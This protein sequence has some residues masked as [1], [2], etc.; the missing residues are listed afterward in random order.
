MK[1]EH[2]ILIVDDEFSVLK[3]L[4]KTLLRKGYSVDTA[5]NGLEAS[6]KLRHKHFD[7]VV[8]EL[9]MPELDGLGL[10]NKAKEID[11][12]II[13][14]LIT[15]YGSIDNAVEA[16]KLGA[17]DY[18]TKPFSPLMLLSV[19]EKALN[20]KQELHDSNLLSDSD[21]VVNELKKD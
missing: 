7:V 8:S 1:S 2:S 9:V 6:E 16:I 15:A 5:N 19:I 3:G 21:S 13:F 12:N 4:K 10:L 18:I 14:L 20:E 17:F 11:R